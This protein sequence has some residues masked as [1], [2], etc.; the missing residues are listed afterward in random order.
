M[1]KISFDFFIINLGRHDLKRY[2]KEKGITK[3][4]LF[5]IKKM[6]RPSQVENTQERD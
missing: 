6:E 3:A 1:T 4:N 2:N 5:K